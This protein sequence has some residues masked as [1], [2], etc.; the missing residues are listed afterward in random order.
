MLRLWNASVLLCNNEILRTYEVLLRSTYFVLL[1]IR[2]RE[3]HF[4]DACR[5][6]ELTGVCGAAAAVGFRFCVSIA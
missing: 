6:G 3:V 1:G 2:D 4:R 5:G